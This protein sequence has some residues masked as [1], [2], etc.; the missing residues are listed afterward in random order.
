MV[1]LLILFALA[2]AIYT[3]LLIL[4]AIICIGAVIVIIIR[5]LLAFDWKKPDDRKNGQML[6][7]A[8][9]IG[10][11]I[12]GLSLISFG[13]AGGIAAIILVYFAICVLGSLK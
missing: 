7:S 13:L 5:I 6:I 4:A 3:P 11:V 1:I 10:S 9:V 8:L 2:I 12:I